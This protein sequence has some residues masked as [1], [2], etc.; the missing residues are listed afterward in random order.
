MNVDVEKSNIYC[1]LDIKVEEEKC[2]LI[3][4]FFWITLI[5]L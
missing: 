5:D 2:K 3:F 1:Y 4:F